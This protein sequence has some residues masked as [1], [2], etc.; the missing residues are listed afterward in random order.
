[1]RVFPHHARKRK[2]HER[3][4]TPT[5]GST[6]RSFGS[7]CI[8][9]HA[10][11]YGVDEAIIYSCICL[12]I[13]I[14]RLPHRSGRITLRASSFF[15]KSSCL[16]SIC[17][18]IVMTDM[19]LT[20]FQKLDA[21]S[22]RLLFSFRKFEVRNSRNEKWKDGLYSAIH[23][24]DGPGLFTQQTIECTGP[25]ARQRNRVNGNEARLL[26][27]ISKILDLER[28]ADSIALTSLPPSTDYVGA[29]L[30]PCGSIELSP[31]YVAST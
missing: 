7:I 4:Q 12:H 21:Q 6:I 29:I 30:K 25:S 27:K 17:N 18:R 8:R 3:F 5:P 11:L 24:L 2:S 1:M 19:R 23:R 22:K 28:N 10:R 20:P 14:H 26:N 13:D 9:S 16:T 15:F 31:R